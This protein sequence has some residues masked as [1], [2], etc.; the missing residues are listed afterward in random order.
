MNVEPDLLVL[1]AGPAGTG[2]AIAASACGLNTVVVDSA[3]TSG[4]QVYRAMPA[5][6][7][8]RDEAPVDSDLLT[9]EQLRK[10]L[11]ECNAEL[12]F[13]RLVWSVGRDLRVD[14]MGSN[15]PEHW[16]PKALLVA[17]G[18]HERV[19]PFPGWTLPG[20]IGL[21]AAT[22]L[23]KSQLVLPGRQT[24]VAGCGPLLALVAATI[25]KH[26]G[27]V[28]AVLDLA[29]RAEWLQATPALLARPDDF[30]RGLLWRRQL[31]AAKVPWLYRHAIREV[32][33]NNGQSLS[34]H[35]VPVNADGAFKDTTPRHMLADSVTVG[36]GL[37][38]ATDITRLLRAQ[39]EFH[40]DRG[41]WVPVVDENQRT[42]H[43]RLYAAGDGTGIRGAAAAYQAGAIGGYAAALDLGYI[44]QPRFAALTAQHRA[45][46]R[47]AVRS[48][49]AMARLLRERHG[50]VRSIDPD[51][52]VCRCEDV[53]RREI[54]HALD[55][56]AVDVNQLKSWTRCG[57]GPCQGRVCGE[58]V[59]AL[60]ADRSGNRGTAGMFSAR[61]PLRPLD[62]A[63]LTGDFDYEDIP[64]PK[65]APL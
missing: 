40:A 54:E 56:G 30:K 27:Q 33:A 20:V 52:I 17:T 6:F 12:V 22:T 14:T 25:V 7:Q 41:G 51:T 38:P 49:G 64:I 24:L 60:I 61:V 34:V 36:H 4:G 9:G 26:G 31:Q 32:S 2:A 50:L 59:A 11:I 43:Q 53:T 19:V 3:F 5:T 44:D 13:D 29:S 18:A 48:G 39:H 35:A 65:A 16:R 1:G 58:T 23:L 45:R 10:A 37:V 57:M 42:T 8:R 55:Q 47:A 63:T 46:H 62:L 15:G 21:A 28:V